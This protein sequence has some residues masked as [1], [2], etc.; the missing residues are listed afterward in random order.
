M[1]HVSEPAHRPTFLLAAFIIASIPSIGLMIYRR[2]RISLSEL[3]MGIALGL[4][5]V[6][7]SYFLLKSLQYFPGFIVFPVVSA[8]GLMF[9]TFYATIVFGEKLSTKSY[10]GIGIATIALVLLNWLPES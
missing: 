1:K 10:I 8:G 9:I 2:K 3:S 4:S 7:Q 6:L 5:N